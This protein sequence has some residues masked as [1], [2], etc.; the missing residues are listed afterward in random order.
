MKKNLFDLLFEDSSIEEA[1]GISA[2]GASLAS[3]GQVA[4]YAAPLGAKGIGSDEKLEKGFWRKR[5]GKKVKTASPEVHNP[6]ALALQEMPHVEYNDYE[7]KDFKVETMPVSPEEKH[8]IMK[9]FYENGVLCHGPDGDWMFCT[10]DDVRPATKTEIADQTIPHLDV[11]LEYEHDIQQESFGAMHEPDF[12]GPAM[13]GLWK[14]LENE[15]TPVKTASPKL[16]KKKKNK[17]Q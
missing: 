5:A 12:K 9:A 10:L 4:G 2:G 13:P 17:H 6:D 1:I 16:H 14:G 7:P 3:S 8:E 15:K 11:T